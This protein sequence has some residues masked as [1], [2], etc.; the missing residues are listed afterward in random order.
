[1]VDAIKRRDLEAARGAMHA[2]LQAALHRHREA[3]R[4]RPPASGQT[5]SSGARVSKR[6]AFIPVHGTWKPLALARMPIRPAEG[7]CRSRPN[8]AL[9]RGQ[10]VFKLLD[11]TGRCNLGP[12]QCPINPPPGTTSSCRLRAG[13]VRF[14]CRVNPERE[15]QQLEPT[16]IAPYPCW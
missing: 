3:T 4:E 7:L 13:Q 16:G 10:P 11:S 1:M 2:H 9:S 14:A 12:F 6:S 8:I 15:G 5:E